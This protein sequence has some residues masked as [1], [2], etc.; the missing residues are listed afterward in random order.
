[1]ILDTHWQEYAVCRQ[2]DPDL[3]FEEG[4]NKREWEQKVIQSAC[5]VC[6]VR[7]RCLDYA[8]SHPKPQWGVWGG[9]TQRQH[10]ALRAERSQ[11]GQAA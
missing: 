2:F 1:M 8:L 10:R 9:L 4:N 11:D 3:F 5:R 7:Q 6:P